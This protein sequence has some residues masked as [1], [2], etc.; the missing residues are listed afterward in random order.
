MP[1]LALRLLLRRFSLLLA[2]YLLLRLG[3]YW[4]NH[5]TFQE[6]TSGQVLL[7][8]WHGFRFDIAALLL[9]NLPWLVL[10]VVPTYGHGWQRL[11]RV[12]Y[13]LLNTLGIALNI[14]DAEYFKFI[15]RRTSNELT[16][17]GDDVRRQ[18]GQLVGQYWYLL[19]P[20]LTLLALLWWLY[21][22]PTPSV[23]REEQTR[24]RTQRP[25]RRYGSW[26]AQLVLLIGL[27]VLGIRGGVAAETLTYRRGL[28]ATASG[29]RP[30][31]AQQHLHFYQK[32]GLPEH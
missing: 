12:L 6:A 25:A 3:F 5:T 22:M 29:A 31:G 9:L 14:I 24:Q 8:F 19:L 16:T 13:V 2:V 10:S 11:L 26:A 30:F 18:A 28:C 4:A 27:I 32:P 20:L 21:P 17:I 23:I 7:A 1:T 15:G